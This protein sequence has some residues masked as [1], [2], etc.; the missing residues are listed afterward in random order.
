MESR[1]CY[2]GDFGAGEVVYSVGQVGRREGRP[3]DEEGQR[4]GERCAGKYGARVSRGGGAEV[5]KRVNVIGGWSLGAD[6]GIMDRL[7]RFLDYE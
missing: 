5:A 3:R 4:E 1:G 6:I 7:M 2:E